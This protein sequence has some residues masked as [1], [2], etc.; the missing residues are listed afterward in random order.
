MAFPT[1]ER[2]NVQAYISWLQMLTPN[3]M[4]FL[5]VYVVHYIILYSEAECLIHHL[6]HEFL[7]PEM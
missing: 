6:H 2:T 1:K 5:D 3:P 7:S 4:C